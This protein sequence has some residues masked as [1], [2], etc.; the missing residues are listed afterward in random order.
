M[1]YNAHR[2]LMH[3]PNREI[4]NKTATID[5]ALN[6]DFDV[7]LDLWVLNNKF[8]L[9]HEISSIEEVDF[10]YIEERKENLWIHVKNT[11]ALE[12]LSTLGSGLHFFWHQEDCYT[13]T[14]KSIPWIYP[15]CEVVTTGVVV[16][17]ELVMDIK[18]INSSI[19]M[20]A[21][22]CSDYVNYIRESN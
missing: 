4:E 3:G 2:G 1:I 5:I 22:V 20:A 15:G 21:G 18:A 9:G 11:S 10:G 17:P 12:K 13:L 7:E 16:M 8:Y 19:V 14:S 6:N